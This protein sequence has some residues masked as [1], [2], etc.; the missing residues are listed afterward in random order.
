MS[1]ILP[2]WPHRFQ[3]S[4][5]KKYIVDLLHSETPAHVFANICWMNFKDLVELENAYERFIM[6]DSNEPEN[7]ELALDKLLSLLIQDE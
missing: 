7:K 1:F 5:F 2:S 6:I 3:N 4:G